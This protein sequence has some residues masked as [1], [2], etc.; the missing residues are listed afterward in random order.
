MTLRTLG[1]LTLFAETADGRSE[2]LYHSGKVLALLAYLA[3]EQRTPTSRQRL[4]ALF[5]GDQESGLARRSLRQA[6]FKL[7]KLVG[8][9]ALELDDD[10]V[11][12]AAGA[13]DVDR[14][15]FLTACAR[16]DLAAASA[17]YHGPFCH[18]FSSEGALEFDQWAEGERRR[19][20]RRFT[21][22]LTR[23]AR[24]AIDAVELERAVALAT[25][26]RDLEPEAEAGVQ[27]LI[28][29]LLASVLDD[30]ARDVA[31]RYRDVASEVGVDTSA[32]MSKVLRRLE[33][34][35]NVRDGSASPSDAG[36]L[37]SFGH[38]FVGRQ[39]ELQRL[40][41]AAERARRG[42]SARVVVVGPAGVGKSR[43]FD[44]L[45]S[46]LRVRGVSVLRVR[47]WPGAR[48]VAYAAFAE[49]VGKLAML[50][51]AG[52]ISVESASTVVQLL[53][54]LREH[55][56]AA[57]PPAGAVQPHQY[58]DAL[59][60]LW[61]ATSEERLLALLL[62]DEH[63]ADAHSRA[64]IEAAWRRSDLSLFLAQATR[65]AAPY[66]RDAA[67]WMRV[68]AAWTQS[69]EVERIDLAGLTPAEIRKLLESVGALPP[70]PWVDRACATLY[71][72]TRG[73]PLEVIETLRRAVQGGAIQLQHDRWVTADV[74]A[75]LD[76][77]TH[78]VGAEQEIAA[79][80]ETALLAL[81]ALAAWR[82]PLEEAVLLSVVERL[83]GRGAELAAAV[84]DLEERGFMSRV[85]RGWRV[86]HDSVID[87][88]G[89]IAAPVSMREL[90]RAIVGAWS[91]TPSLDWDAC[92][93][94]A[95]LCGSAGD[96][97][98][99]GFVVDAAAE[100][101]LQPTSRQGGAW[102]ARTL[103][104][105][106]GHAEWAPML[107]RRMGRWRR[108]ALRTQLL[109]AS[110]GTVVA[111]VGG[112]L[113][114]ELR[115]R[116]VVE[117]MPAAVNLN[118]TSF[119]LLTQPR[120]AM[121]DGFGRR[122]AS[123]RGDVSVSAVNEGA[124]VSDER[125]VPVIAGVAQFSNL[126]LQ[127]VG[128]PD[129]LRL[130]F[131]APGARGATTEVLGIVEHAFADSLAFVRGTLNGKPLDPAWH[132][133]IAVGERADVVLTV[134]YRTA[135]ANG[136]VILGA[137]PTWEPR[138][139]ASLR[140]AG[141]P[142]PVRNGRI[143]VRFS[144]EPPRAP[145]HFHVFVLM[146][147]EERVEDIFSQTNWALG[148][149]RWNDGNDVFDLPEDSVVLL[150]ARNRLVMSNY[151]LPPDTGTMGEGSASQRESAATQASAPRGTMARRGPQN[152][153]G[154]V[155]EVDVVRQP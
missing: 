104:G 101:R 75:L 78:S 97:E 17:A 138:E 82:K 51:G 29:A 149:P 56:H 26:L 107:V 22:A 129:A 144:L 113:A 81:Q 63:N 76:V 8:E 119:R 126:G 47:L 105:A 142:R 146:G 132:A 5:W 68:A 106:A 110:G 114:A 131:S 96:V 139:R 87:A 60:D 95:G 102:L 120:I 99:L 35:S 91:A 117:T 34:P 145:G 7:R 15:R 79:L 155:I 103:S 115:P 40:L 55:F 54:Q 61:A 137:A 69:T 118:G 13:V 20:Q 4:A 67:A 46:R 134:D 19:L 125:R 18:G 152:I 42:E 39:V 93:H 148:G 6:L 45:E 111:L 130:R 77:L 147:M 62:D 70:A 10:A 86:A 41:V 72:R 94:L 25:Q 140:L 153:R 31:S 43:L 23:G 14:E 2:V 154:S 85:P 80:P 100:H 124:A 65:V 30:E 21:E 128:N 90:L 83:G 135:T 16:G 73:R 37:L 84:R 123:F 98:A 127:R 50:P 122:V 150:R 48:V 64:V 136:N 133:V 9:A 24:A 88:V 58:A 89:G 121:E 109:L 143:T 141:L 57:R 66:T 151:L 49:L 116:I 32:G 108:M 11:R 28:E 27:L 3:V 71:E 33:Q 1:S 12:L 52:G 44:E 74:D 38:E 59:A 53:P 112:Y 36:G 92:L